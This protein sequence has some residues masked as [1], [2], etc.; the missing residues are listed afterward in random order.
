MEYELIFN[1]ISVQ[2]PWN[3]SVKFVVLF[4][5]LVIYVLFFQFHVP[6]YQEA[7]MCASTELICQ[8]AIHSHTP[9][10]NDNDD[11]DKPTTQQ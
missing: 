2:F 4:R 6:N 1:T 5:F 8:N 3:E 10:E 11:D 7:R 9:D